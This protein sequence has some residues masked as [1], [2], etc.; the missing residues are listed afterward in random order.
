MT[1]G[2]FDEALF[3]KGIQLHFCRKV[4]NVSEVSKE[5]GFGEEDS[6]KE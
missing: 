3:L 1:K 6:K 5:S 4:I 2:D